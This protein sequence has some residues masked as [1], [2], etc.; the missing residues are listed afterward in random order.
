[1]PRTSF[2]DNGHFGLL[3]QKDDLLTTFAALAVFV[4]YT[5]PKM[6]RWN[7]M[8][9]G[10]ILFYLVFVVSGVGRASLAGLAFGSVLLFI[11]GQK[12]FF[13]YPALGLLVGITLVASYVTGYGDSPESAPSIFVEK[14]QSMVDVSGT[15]NYSSAYGEQKAMNNEFRRRLWESFVED[16]DKESPMFGRGF[17]VDFLAHFEATF[18]RGGW[19]GLR[20]AHNFYVTLYGRMG[21]A[22]L[23]IFLAITGQIFAG[24]VRAALLV[25][26]GLYPLADLGYWCGVWTILISS[27]VGVVLEGPVGAVVFWTFLG[28]AAECSKTVNAALAEARQKALEFDPVPALPERRPLVY[29]RA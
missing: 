2:L 16:T 9:I 6:F 17:G 25:R 8:R 7:W 28:V 29:G 23:L 1:M 4:I 15:H 10:M 22:G 26:A 21:A 20:S 11:A 5:R 12:R 14:L 27:V 19:E 3:Y 24:G 13:I 18:Q